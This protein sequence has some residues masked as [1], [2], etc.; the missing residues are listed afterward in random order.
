MILIVS[1]I[2]K[3]GMQRTPF[4]GFD[5]VAHFLEY[6]V[7]GIALRYW[8]GRRRAYHFFGGV[9]F[10]LADEFHQKFIPGREA[11]ILDFTADAAGVAFGYLLLGRRRIGHGSKN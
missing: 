4:P 10:G 1:S 9:V 6:M 5:K 3:I 8:S 7:L 11:S 2:P